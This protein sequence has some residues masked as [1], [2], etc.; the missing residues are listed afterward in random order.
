MLKKY[1]IHELSKDINIPNKE[2]IAL[3][4]KRFEGS[5][6]HMTS[7][8]EQEL[9]FIFEHYTKKFECKSFENYFAPLKKKSV[10]KKDIE[11]ILDSYSKKKEKPIKKARKPSNKSKKLTLEDLKAQNPTSSNEKKES[12]PIVIKKQ[13]VKVINTKTENINIDKYNNKYENIASGNNFGKSFD[14]STKQKIS[15]SNK[16]KRFRKHESESERLKRIEHDRKTKPIKILIP[17]QITVAELAFRLKAT[18]GEVIKKLVD[19]GV[20]ASVNDVIDFDTAYLAAMEFNAKVE[21]EVTQ[22]IEELVINETDDLEENL[23]PRAPIVVVMG[24]VDHGKT[25]ILDYIRKSNVTSKESGGITQHIGAY[26]ADFKSQKITFLDTPGHEAFT[27][28]RA[29]GAQVTDIAVIVIAADDGIMPQTV[30]AINHAKDAGVSIIVAINKID[31]PGADIERVKRQLME[32]GL[33]SE[34]LGGDVICVPVSAKEGTGISDLLESILLV[35]EMKELKSNPDKNASGVV[36]ES[37]IAKGKGVVAT[38]LVMKGTLKVGDLVVAGVSIGKVRSLNNEFGEKVKFAAPSEPV[39]ITGLDIAPQ[40]GEQFNVVDNDKLAHELVEQRKSKRKNERLDSVQKVNF[41][42]FFDVM[43]QRDMKELK[44]VLKADVNGS[45]EALKQSL[46]KLSNDEILVKVIHSGV[47][48]INESDVMLS[49]A[50]GA[51][52]VGFNVKVTPDAKDNSRRQGINIKLYKVIYDCINEVSDLMKG[53]LVPET[54]E[55]HSGNAECRKIFKITGV[56]V[57]AGCYV[58]DGKIVRGLF[59]HVKRDGK[60]LCSE[61]IVSLKKYKDDEKEVTHG[62]ECGILLEKFVDYEVGDIIEAYSV[63]N[64]EK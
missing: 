10:S 46:E 1:R 27:S 55:V 19:L 52:L 30:E 31:K 7:L 57:V 32:H 41:E 54:Q 14:Y 26:R 58:T 17:E 9:D 3:L 39:E 18:V 34:E 4:K 5:Y 22:S 25:S 16:N 43:K 38:V 33:V 13:E 50:S 28:M 53:M 44:I 12:S 29:R 8:K 62:F 56:G 20:M 49:S 47:G 64:C 21:K 45:V 24:H 40:G 11:N 35:A 15:K 42:N 23:K 60:I 36:I 63:E 6:S 59:A 2:L 51:L 61:K 37:K 48:L